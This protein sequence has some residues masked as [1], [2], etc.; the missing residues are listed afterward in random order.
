ML[1]LLLFICLIVVV[2]VVAGL[3]QAGMLPGFDHDSRSSRGSGDSRMLESPG[4]LLALIAA[5][6]V[7][8]AA[9][10]VVLILSLRFLR[11]VI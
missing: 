5:S 8:F 2:G 7:W 3:G 4:C 11:S 1:I 10:G 6:V 9:W